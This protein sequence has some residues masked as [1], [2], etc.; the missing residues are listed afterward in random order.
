VTSIDFYFNAEDR[1]QVA[2]R[3][4]GKALAQNKRLLI[5]APEPELAGRIDRLLWSWP[6]IGFVPHVPAHDPLAAE[7]P[8]LIGGGEDTP[9]GVSLLLNLSAAHPPHFERFERLLEVVGADEEEKKAGRER[10]RFYRDRGYPIASH[11]LSG[12][13]RGEKRAGADG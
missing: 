13:T 2:C 4:A 9:A 3:L 1:L 10:F 12:E 6:A 11:D 8:V 7:T 5:Y